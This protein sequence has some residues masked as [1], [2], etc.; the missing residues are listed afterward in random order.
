MLKNQLIPTN[1]HFEI[2][3]AIKNKLGYIPAN[4]NSNLITQWLKNNLLIKEYQSSSYVLTNYGAAQLEQYRVKRGVILAAGL[5]TRMLPITNTIPKPLVSINNTRIIET[6]IRALTEAGIS[7][8][9]IVVGHLAHKF[10]VLL[11][12]W[13]NL[14]LVTNAQYKTTNNITS[15]NLVSDKL[16]NCYL[17]EADIFIQ[18]KSIIR[19]YEYRSNYCGSYVLSCNDWYFKKRGDLIVGLDYQT[20]KPCHQYI[21]ISYWTEDEG[22]KL[23]RNIHNAC[24]DSA[25]WKYFNEDI[26]FNL[27]KSHHKL[28]LRQIEKSD[29][30]ELD[31][32]EELS[33]FKR[34]FN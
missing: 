12:T 11:D 16:N 32:L 27:Y 25:N 24:K 5:G 31:T 3:L 9:T 4:I 20:Q 34:S 14:K 7:D 17:I 23:A 33:E 30:I 13:P 26:P 8:I 1:D 18:N 21:G 6:S 22:K 2:L 15:V 10:D 19:S 29:A 28:Y